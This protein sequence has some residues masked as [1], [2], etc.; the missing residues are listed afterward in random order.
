MILPFGVKI[1]V[2]ENLTEDG[3]P[4]EITRTWKERLFTLPWKPLR[5]TKTVIPQVPSSQ[6]YGLEDGT[7]VMHPETFRR[8]EVEIEAKNRSA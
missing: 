7:F 2:N 4:Y 5:K 1:I 6:I 8:L 3:E